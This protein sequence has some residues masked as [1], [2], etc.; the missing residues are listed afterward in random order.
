VREDDGLWLV[1][2]VRRSTKREYYVIKPMNDKRWD[3]HASYP[4][5]RSPAP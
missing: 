3:V 1:L 5:Q 4:R 2:W